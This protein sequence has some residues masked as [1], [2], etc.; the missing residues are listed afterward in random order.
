VSQRQGNR[1]DVGKTANQVGGVWLDLGMPDSAVASHRE[2]LTIATELGDRDDEGSASNNLALA[3]RRMAQLDSAAV[4]YQRSLGITRQLGNRHAEATVLNNLGSVLWSVNRFDTALAL[5]RQ[6][7]A[8][9]ET[10]GDR[11]GSAQTLNNIAT[12]LDEIDQMDSARV[13]Y[14]RS[15]RLRRELGD[16]R[17]E[18]QVL[19]NIGL[20]QTRLGRLDSA[21]QF[22]GS[23]LRGRRETGDRPGQA[24]TLHTL[25]TVNARRG[26]GDTAAS[27]LRQSLALRR[28]VRDRLGVAQVLSS[29]GGLLHR[30]RHPNLAG[31][32]AYY[33]SAAAEYSELG[34]IAGNDPNRV[35]HAERTVELYREW[36]LA[37][38]ARGPEIGA[39]AARVA[40]LAASDRGRAQALLDLRRGGPGKPLHAGG[41]LAKEGDALINGL[42]DGSTAALVYQ[43][44]RDTL[45]IWL[46]APKQAPIVVRQALNRDSLAGLV[47]DYRR[48]LRV[49]DAPLT[50]TMRSAP[51]EATGD[52][53][54]ARAVRPLVESATRLAEAVLPP[55]VRALLGD[56]REIVIVPQGSIGL[57]PFT[58]LP[59]GPEGDP[60]G[61]RHAVRYAP[62]LANLALSE[63]GGAAAPRPDRSGAL[64]IGNP[65]MPE[66][67]G[68][69]GRRVSLAPLPGAAREAAAVAGYFGATPLGATDATESTVRA[70]L[71]RARLVHL[72]THAYAYSGA[73]SARRSFVA[74]AP[75]G[76]HDGLLTV[77]EVM[78]DPSL[79]LSA[80]LVVLS[81]CQTG[82]G[83]LREAEGSIGLQRAF[84]AR[85]AKSLLVS[86]WSVSDAIAA[87]VMESFYRSWLTDR[88]R[89]SKAEAL[90]RAQEAV[91]RMPGWEHPR[92]WAAFQVVGGR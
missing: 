83:N 29:L 32:V 31:A 43:L 23:A 86:L 69:E 73:E 12:V 37:W 42:G 82:L 68:A 5:Y 78:D 18:A 45:V 21:D 81:A 36:T 15:L 72:A 79:D 55:A 41:D 92:G 66:V 52:R 76:G 8:V 47:S 84:L 48:S 26:L 10:I 22:L 28:E 30:D 80:E 17:G 35:S 24:L 87:T 3:Y 67:T 6:A 54:P 25:A 77:A 74:L 16:R 58:A 70:R 27:Y 9:R 19:H 2:A 75:G 60:L 14:D 91:R 38:L 34:I 11:F 7:L 39:V 40:A 64:V 20:F 90:R 57:I 49:D 88:D 50:I 61:A 62:S 33:D 13:Y 63:Q 44:T 56:A 89:P 71:P 51:L 1:L 4:Y 85:G 65:P 46:V 53:G 59:F